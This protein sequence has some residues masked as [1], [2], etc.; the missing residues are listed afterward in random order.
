MGSASGVRRALRGTLSSGRA[1]LAGF[2]LAALVL[3]CDRAVPEPPRTP[4]ARPP[5]AEEP[6]AE[7]GPPACR[8][9]A[10]SGRRTVEHDGLA[11]SFVVDVP[12]RRDPRAPLLLAFHGW[13]GDPQQL[14]RTTRLTERA[15][16]RGWVVVRPEGF[17]RS[18][19]AGTC[20]GQAAER[21][22]DDVGFVRKIIGS[23][24]SEE[25]VDP[26]RVFATGFSNGGFLAH[27]LG[28]EAADLVAGVAAV[29][30]TI[31][32]E[33]CA[34]SRPVA[35]L[36][37]HG[38]R[39]GIIPFAGRSAKRILGVPATIATWSRLSG[40]MPERVEDFVPGAAGGAPRG[41]RCVRRAGCLGGTE[42]TLCRDPGL[43]HA[44]PK[45]GPDATG[46]DATEIVL[47]FFE[48]HPRE[49]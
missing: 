4:A 8:P 30:G 11:R 19:A 21:R 27:R 36:Q 14:E 26:G 15:T 18:F 47:S 23:I 46:L 33:T 37:I 48:R 35:V 25:C 32:I 29:A 9:R 2:A 10:A 41:V 49:R 28:C 34:P 31:S 40:C 7:H 42:V 17:Q 43:A 13:G 39:D 5:V 22:L 12:A 38:E 45:G 24:G 6:L 1:A 44:W 16:G 20:C 3:D